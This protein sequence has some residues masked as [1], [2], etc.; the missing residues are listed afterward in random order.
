MLIGVLSCCSFGMLALA[1]TILKSPP[2][3]PLFGSGLSC[4]VFSH[5]VMFRGFQI[6][7][8]GFRIERV[9]AL[10]KRGVRV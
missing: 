4:R 10:R 2:L 7:E 1:L 9:Q 8:L 5:A 3:F 6:M